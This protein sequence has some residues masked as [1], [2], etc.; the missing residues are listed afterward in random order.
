MGQQDEIEKL[1][2]DVLKLE[3]SNQSL[4]DFYS[5]LSTRHRLTRI[6]LFRH[7]FFTKF[8][9]G[10][11]LIWSFFTMVV[12]GGCYAFLSTSLEKYEEFGWGLNDEIQK[13]PM[14]GIGIIGWIVILCLIAF[15]GIYYFF[16]YSNLDAEDGD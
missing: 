8:I 3:I 15:L 7:I 6:R 2:Q 5:K 13:V 9:L 4:R 16:H 10:S 1:K 12:I 11:L 14:F